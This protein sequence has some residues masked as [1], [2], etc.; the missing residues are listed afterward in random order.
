[1]A[2]LADP[3][4]K[5]TI[6]KKLDAFSQ[7]ENSHN[8]R[9][10]LADL[11]SNLG[12]IDIGVKYGVLGP[13]EVHYLREEWFPRWQG[14]DVEQEIRRGLIDAVRQALDQHL[15]IDSYWIYADPDDP[16]WHQ[17][18]PPVDRVTVEVFRNPRD[19]EKV[20]NPNYVRVIT[21]NIYTPPLPS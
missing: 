7:P 9:A 16:H 14:Q 20:K 21:L 10:A 18:R 2:D 6:L 13:G 12:L 19:E 4:V 8:L 17:I 3:V 15:P 11:Q 1:M 5:G